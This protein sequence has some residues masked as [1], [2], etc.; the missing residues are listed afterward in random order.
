MKTL[1]VFLFLG[2]LYGGSLCAQGIEGAW[3]KQSVSYPDSS[4]FVPEEDILNYDYYR[5]SFER[6]SICIRSNRIAEK[7]S[8]VRY[9]IN[10][11][12]LSFEMEGGFV[13]EKCE[14]LRLT[15]DELV[16]KRGN[17]CWGEEEL[18]YHFVREDTFK[19][20]LE[21]I[22]FEIASMNGADTVYKAN[23]RVCPLFVGDYSLL[24]YLYPNIPEINNIMLT[25]NIFLATFVIGKNGEVGTPDIQKR[26]NRYFEE[27]F[28]KALNGTK[29]QWVPATLN[30]EKVNAQVSVEFFFHSPEVR[31]ELLDMEEKIKE[32][33]QQENYRKARR[34]IHRVLEIDPTRL[35]YLYDIAILDL[36]VGDF[37]SACKSFYFLQNSEGFQLEKLIKEY[38]P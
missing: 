33:L 5:L 31:F 10:S 28:V 3:V 1:V 25:D 22:P 17:K 32:A 18:L 23:A 14:I 24:H 19:K 30:G 11:G 9:R 29:G 35:R 4:R 36:L 13:V 20:S 12:T 8:D 21:A 7:G 26:I 37:S 15:E 6:D 16:L 2:L 38:C 34:Y 27:Q